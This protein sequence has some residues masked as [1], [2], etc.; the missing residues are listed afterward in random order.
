M[1]ETRKPRT[2]DEMVTELEDR[3]RQDEKELYGEK[4]IEEAYNPKNVGV[5]EN[6]DGAASI[7]DSHGDTMQ[8][9]IKV[10]GERLTDSKFTTDGRGITVAFGSVLTELAIGK[11]V[12]DAFLIEATDI[13]SVLG[14]LP[15]DDEHTPEL[16]V[17]TLRA[18]LEDYKK[19]H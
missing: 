11:T 8:I 14:S 2:F 17:N 19:K 12:E 1:T 7:T 16:A 9:H 13:V 5:L 6:L 18:A 10:E 4:T 3:I 15:A